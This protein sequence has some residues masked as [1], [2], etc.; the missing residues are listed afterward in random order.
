MG[1]LLALAKSERID[2]SWYCDLEEW[3]SGVLTLWPSRPK[4]EFLAMLGEGWMTINKD[5]YSCID[6]ILQIFSIK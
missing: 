3:D 1:K 6:L 5:R 4:I 2:Y